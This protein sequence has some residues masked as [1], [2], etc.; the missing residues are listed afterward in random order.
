M[1]SDSQCSVTSDHDDRSSSPRPGWRHR[2]VRLAGEGEWITDAPCEERWSAMRAGGRVALE[3][4]RVP[5]SSPFVLV[6]AQDV[7]GMPELLEKDKGQD[8]VGP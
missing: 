5:A 6:L 8:G 2:I 4:L 1:P 7:D 3:V